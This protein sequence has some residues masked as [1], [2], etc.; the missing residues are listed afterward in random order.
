MYFGTVTVKNAKGKNPSIIDADGEDFTTIIGSSE[1]NSTLLTVDNTTSSPV[2][3]DS[4][5]ININASNRTSAVKI[6]WQC[7]P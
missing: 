7:E 3:V 6:Y 4:N 2:T 1:I 5:I